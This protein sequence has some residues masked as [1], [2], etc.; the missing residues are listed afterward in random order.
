MFVF[1]SCP[2]SDWWH[3][4]ALK[5]LEWL[6]LNPKKSPSSLRSQEFDLVNNC[7]GLK[8]MHFKQ[9]VQ[10]QKNYAVLKVPGHA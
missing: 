3:F 5:L 7:A 9:K 6:Q 8:K 2:F 1:F 10:S 4:D